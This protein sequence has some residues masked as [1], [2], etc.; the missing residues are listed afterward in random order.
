MERALA[1]LTIDEEEDVVL[2]VGAAVQVEVPQYQYCMVARR[3]TPVVSPW[4]RD[5]VDDFG[6]DQRRA[7][8]NPGFVGMQYSKF[9]DFRASFLGTTSGGKQILPG[10]G[11][12]TRM[13]L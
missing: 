2:N 11:Q 4:I 10:Y 9:K 7:N 6:G 1:T 3:N 13:E 5:E 12:P 8:L